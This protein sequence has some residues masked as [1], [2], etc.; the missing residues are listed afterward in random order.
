MGQ[1]PK[2]GATRVMTAVHWQWLR[3]ADLG[4]DN[5]YDLLALR[6]Q[7]FVLEQGPFLDPDGVD[8][9][10]WHLLGRDSAGELHAYLRLVDPGIKY[11]EPSMGR[12]I[13][14]LQTR[15]TGLG[16]ALVAQGLQ[17]ADQA[18]PQH[19]NRISAQ[20]HLAPFYGAFGYVGVGEPYIEDTIPHLQMLRP[21]PT[22]AK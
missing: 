15:G 7:V 5:L 17:R 22:V 1:L 21:A 16:R 8:R 14:S 11:A 3:F 10:C 18:W 13:T 9:Q 2:P 19:G 6:C 4:V 20:A 12:V